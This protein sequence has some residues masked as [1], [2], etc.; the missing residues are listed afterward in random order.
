MRRHEKERQCGHKVRVKW[1]EARR[2]PPTPAS[3]QGPE[4]GGTRYR[5]SQS[6]SLPLQPCSTPQTSQP[7]WILNKQL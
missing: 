7:I 6:T 5:G 2:S 4:L 1:Q 3:G